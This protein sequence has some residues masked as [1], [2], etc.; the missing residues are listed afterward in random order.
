MEL[1]WRLWAPQVLSVVPSSRFT[2]QGTGTTCSSVAPSWH[3]D[4]LEEGTDLVIFRSCIS[5]GLEPQRLAQSHTTHKNPLVIPWW[6]WSKFWRKW[7]AYIGIEGRVKVGRMWEDLKR[8]VKFTL[9]KERFLCVSG[10][11]KINLWK[12]R[13]VCETD[14]DRQSY[15]RKMRRWV[16]R[17][18]IQ[19]FFFQGYPFIVFPSQEEFYFPHQLNILNNN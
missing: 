12:M 6:E 18:R 14:T 17:A 13:C 15:T 16:R 11:M 8:R 19:S 9:P 10:I 5:H 4:F 3:W 1:V 2:V 7:A